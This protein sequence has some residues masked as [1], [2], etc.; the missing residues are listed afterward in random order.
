MSSRSVHAG[1]KRDKPEHSMTTPVVFSSTF[2][3]PDTEAL[4]AFMEG[5]EERVEE[6]GRY[7][8]PTRNAVEEKLAALENGQAALLFSSGMSAATTTLLALV[9][10][11]SHV[12]FT[13]DCYRK[14]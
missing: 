8:N 10:K 12:I 1:E 2:T 6:Y 4:V 11:D 5:R 14:T 9:Q 3:F 13:N 7:G